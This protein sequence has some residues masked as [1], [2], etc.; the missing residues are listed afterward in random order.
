M[1]RNIVRD[2]VRPVVN[3]VD[4][5]F[6]VGLSQ[7]NDYKDRVEELGGTIQNPSLNKSM[8][9]E[10]INGGYY[11]D[12]YYWIDKRF[13]T[14]TGTESGRVPM[15]SLSF[16]DGN[17]G[18]YDT[19]AYLAS[20]GS[21]RGTFFLN[22][23]FIGTAGKLTWEQVLEM[24]NDGCDMQCHTWSH[25]RSDHF[26]GGD[27]DN[28][29]GLTGC[30]VEQI[31]EELVNNNTEFVANGLPSPKHLS[32]PNY[33]FDFTKVLPLVD[34]YRFSGRS[35]IPYITGLFY[36]PYEYNWLT[37]AGRSINFLDS[38]SVAT[39]KGFIDDA[40]KY[41]CP[42]HLAGHSVDETIFKDL[43]DYIYAY[44]ITPSTVSE[45]YDAIN[46][47]RNKL[48]N[49][50]L[51]DYEALAF[52]DDGRKI[53]ESQGMIIFGETL[54]NITSGVADDYVADDYK[55]GFY[56]DTGDD[57]QAYAVDNTPYYDS[58]DVT[59][60]SGTD[61]ISL[62]GHLLS[63]NMRFKITGGT[64]PSPLILDTAYFVRNNTGG[65]SVQ[66]SGTAG[67]A[68]IDLTDN[69]SALKLSTFGFREILRTY[70]T[71]DNTLTSVKRMLERIY[72]DPDNV[73][74]SEFDF[75]NYAIGGEIGDFGL[76]LFRSMGRD[77]TVNF[78]F[79][80]NLIGGDIP[81]DIY[82]LQNSR[83]RFDFRN[84][85]LTGGLENLMTPKTINIYAA[86]NLIN[87][88]F[89]DRVGDMINCERIELYTNQLSGD[90][91]VE[92]GNCVLMERLFLGGNDLTG[93]EVGAISISMTELI[94]IDFSNNDITA[95]AD[96]NQILADCV[97]LEAAEG[98]VA[99]LNLSGGTNAAPTGQGVTDVNTLTTA[100]W[101]V[102][103]N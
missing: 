93:Y 36:N 69:G 72:V 41:N 47:F 86:D 74:E 38:G 79:R 77:Q 78:N 24:Y 101:T 60:D 49:V 29:L 34:Q 26:P 102:T 62:A 21:G 54:A 82:Y 103:T 27:V 19:W 92:L 20:K 25:A 7:Y 89:P 65:V 32:Y 75:Q 73:L 37:Y 84:N 66:V 52:L 88:A 71:G 1:V 13:G 5:R 87:Q 6:G 68:V 50:P 76:S 11:D 94:F 10:A 12:I 55:V 59:A 53:G 85:K 16:D 18:D 4:D 3:P 90:I 23:K 9:Q 96:I 83:V 14:K 2:V 67:G 64:P 45:H 15:V 8:I 51:N 99:T 61:R 63:N 35:S 48:F 30:T 42:L 22:T 57:A 81:D 43:L 56:T 70:D 39:A 100:G 98:N 80:F 28:D 17:S 31:I 40:V 46:T 95:A 58:V 97:A 44:G 91:P 33:I